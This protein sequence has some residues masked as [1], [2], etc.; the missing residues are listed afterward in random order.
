MGTKADPD[1]FD[2]HARAE[3]DEPLF[4]LLARDPLAPFLVSIWSSLR[5][6]DHEAA[7][8]KFAAML[9]RAGARY[10]PDPDVEKASAAL[11]CA[12]AM[13]AWRKTHRPDEVEPLP[14]DPPSLQARLAECLAEVVDA[15]LLT[16]R[17]VG[18]SGA[19]ELRVGSFRPDLGERSAEILEEAG[20]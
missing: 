16:V 7:G 13:F 6:G 17:D 9:D 4:T 14:P 12:M 15:T 18:S 1:R 11:D 2:C 20:A 10:L 19:I 8:V 3:P 5:Y